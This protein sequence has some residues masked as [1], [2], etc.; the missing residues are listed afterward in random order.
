MH[1]SK[2]IFADPVTK[3][4]IANFFKIFVI[5]V[6]QVLLVPVYLKYWGV[7]I[8]ADWLILTAIVGF[9][10]MSD[11]GL[12]NAT[13]NLFCI[14]YSQQEYRFCK[15][16]ITNNIIIVFGIF[17]GVMLILFLLELCFNIK[18][19][20][21]IK[22]FSLFE[23]NILL[24]L[25]VVQVFVHMLSMVFNSI[26]NSSHLASKATYL[27]NFARLG[28]AFV[29][30]YGIIMDFTITLIV[31]AG[32]VPYILCLIYKIINSKK[33]F[34]YKL[35]LKY[36]DFKLLKDIFVPSIAYLSFPIGNAFLFQCFTLIINKYA[37]GIALVNFNTTRTMAN[38]VRNLVQSVAHGIKPEFSIAYGKGDREKL[39]GLFRKCV[40]LCLFLSVL[41]AVFIEIV[42]EPIYNIWTSNKINFDRL[43]VT[44]FLLIT[45]VNS[46][47][48][49]S[50]I[51]MTATNRYTKLGIVYLSSTAISAIISYMAGWG[52]ANIYFMASSI[53]ISD[54]LMSAY[55]IS[56]SSK[57]LSKS[58]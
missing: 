45:I 55:S 17:L 18:H 21:S 7:E 27:D 44:I 46:I 25:L 54:V 37:G 3:N 19:L 38:F 11:A 14:K 32:V 2:E 15:S 41:S 36:F 39:W 57:I 5:F 23:T 10:T 1:F 53:I 49:S 13:N 43:L 16:L 31:A 6:S 34:D 28:N 26:Y 40:T 22:S 51:V 47:W 58:L 50:S 4:I 29:I 12:N 33:I 48:E 35:S 24:L 8:Y 30:V 52:G 9:F 20:L 56:T 42:G